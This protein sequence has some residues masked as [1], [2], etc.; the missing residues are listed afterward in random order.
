MSREANSRT[1]EIVTELRGIIASE[2]L[3]PEAVWRQVND[4]LHPDD[5]V[6]W[7]TFYLWTK[8]QSDWKSKYRGGLRAESAL[9]LQEWINQHTPQKKNKKS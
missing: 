8:H 5:Q 6:S 7:S 2:K 3:K 4:L 1:S 9:A